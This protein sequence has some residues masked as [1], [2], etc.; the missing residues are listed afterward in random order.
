VTVS[1]AQV[2]I[3]EPLTVTGT[4]TP[5]PPAD[6]TPGG[7][8]AVR[9]GTV[10][11]GQEALTGG[12][13][14]RSVA[15][16]LVGTHAVSAA[17]QGDPVF[18]PSAS[19][20]VYVTVVKGGTAS[21]LATS[22]PVTGRGESLTLTATVTALAPAAG[23]PAGSVK[24][25]TGS[26]TLGSVSL[27]NGVA[28]YTTTALA[29]GAHSLTAV[30]VGDTRFATSTSPAVPHTVDGGTTTSVTSSANP[31]VA[32]QPVTF[33]ATV[34]VVGGG[35]SAPT[36][37][38]SFRR[39]TREL[40]SQPLSDGTARLTVDSLAV[41]K[42]SITAVYLGSDTHAGS[43][44]PVITQVVQKGAT[45]TALSSSDTSTTAGQA[46]TFTVTVVPVAPAAGTPTGKVKLLLNGK[47]IAS[48]SLSGGKAT[49]KTS[50]LPVGRH[51][52]T[53]AYN[54]SGLFATSTSAAVTQDVTQ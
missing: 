45:T 2:R 8:L 7:F 21:V 32:G 3:G 5:I 4:V 38:V 6:G 48:S 20:A 39:G 10:T 24:F 26:T 1:A 15:F 30:Y 41:G 42:S 11:V 22:S 44:S 23:V 25:R 34:A 18:S 31:S 13:A 52:M 51:R 28:T 54:G 49:F 9:D 47:A 29:P 43:T 46:V 40:G 27:V 36:G 16:S 37:R 50:T 12:T 33:T 14:S 53:A 19:A 35:T 17:Y